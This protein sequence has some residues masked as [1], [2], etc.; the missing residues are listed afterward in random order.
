M[1]VLTKRDPL[2]RAPPLPD[3]Y[4]RSACCVRRVDRERLVL[5][6]FP[7]ASLY[8]LL[9]RVVCIFFEEVTLPTLLPRVKSV[10]FP[11]TPIL[12]P[13]HLSFLGATFSTFVAD[14]HLRPDLPQYIFSPSYPDV[15]PEGDPRRP[16]REPRVL[17][18]CSDS[19]H[20]FVDDL[21]PPLVLRH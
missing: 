18:A 17:T 11:Q 12:F 3:P 20:L 21:S 10:C 1:P 6:F 5:F 8:P 19:L 16:S 7:P 2:F 15:F 13:S 9:L 4:G 14:L